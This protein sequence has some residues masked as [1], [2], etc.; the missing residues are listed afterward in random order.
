MKN[1]IFKLLFITM[2]LMISCDKQDNSIKK[3]E[4]IKS[5]TKLSEDTFLIKIRDMQMAGNYLYLSDYEANRILILDSNFNLIRSF[6]RLGSGPGEFRGA[7]YLQMY[8]DSI[9]VVSVGVK[10]M[11]IYNTEGEFKRSFPLDPTVWASSKF[12]IDQFENFYFSSLTNKN[13]PMIKCDNNG[14]LIKGFGKWIPYK[15]TQEKLAINEMDLFL[16][17][18]KILVI[19]HGSPVINIYSLDGRY[20]ESFSLESNLFVQRRLRFAKKEISK[21]TT[22]RAITYELFWYGSIFNN[23]LYLLLVDFDKSPGTG[24]N[25]I[26]VVD[27]N[28]KKIIKTFLLDS[29]GWY[30]SFTVAG[31]KLIAF[32][33]GKYSELQIFIIN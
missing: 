5:I 23:K 2:L 29:G 25:K 9:Y 8:N 1:K 33:S 24:Q 22:K 21:L 19:T 15:N 10:R 17:G 12:V 16:Y 20:I 30:D 32:K 27:L 18:N 4:K 6:G 28:S 31:N 26:L 14:I 11:N 7:G 3:L 13:F